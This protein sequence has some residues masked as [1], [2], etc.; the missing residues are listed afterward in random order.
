MK[1]ILALLLFFFLL[2]GCNS[3]LAKARYKTEVSNQQGAENASNGSLPAAPS[4][5]YYLRY[6][7]FQH[8]NSTTREA[9]L[10][11]LDSTGTRNIQALLLEGESVSS[12]FCSNSIKATFTGFLS[13]DYNT[14]VVAVDYLNKTEVFNVSRNDGAVMVFS[15]G[16]VAKSEI[17]LETKAEARRV[18]VGEKEFTLENDFMVDNSCALGRRYNKVVLAHQDW[19]SKK[20]DDDASLRRYM[21][22][23]NTVFCIGGD[24]YVLEEDE[25][26]NQCYTHLGKRNADTVGCRNL[27]G[28][29]GSVA[30]ED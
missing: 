19:H 5:Y 22:R 15:C 3:I 9:Q 24:M 25:Y 28:A 2:F 27:E 11:F 13:P 14:I 30:G 20:F 7:N 1:K 26:S 8:A 16:G 29:I 6:Y 23:P 10:E 12:E 18:F 21:F 4:G 17:R